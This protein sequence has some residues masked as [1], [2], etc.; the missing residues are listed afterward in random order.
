MYRIFRT[1]ICITILAGLA[2][3]FAEN[4][5]NSKGTVGKIDN[6]TYTYSE[7]NQILNNY[8][9]FWQSRDG[10][11]LTADRKKQLNDQCWEELIGRAIYDGEIKRR[12]I[13]ITDTEAYNS[14]LA[15]PP[16]QVKQ[17]ESL[18]TNGKFDPAKFKKALEV[19][20]K[21]KQQVMDLVKETMVYDRLFYVIKSQVKAKPDSIKQ[22]WL[23]DNNLAS[24][25]IIVFD[26]NKAKGITVADSEAFKYYNNNKETYK[27]DPARKYKFVKFTQDMYAEKSK[28]KAKAD[29]LYQVIKAG[30][31]FA[32]LATTFSDD[33]GSGK[34]GGELGWFTREKMVKPFADAA[35]ALDVNGISVPVKSQFG[36]HIIQTE[37]KRK[38]EQGQD[39]V[40]AR[41]LLV[42]SEPEEAIKQMVSA[43]AEKFLVAAKASGL[44]TAAAA[45]NYPVTETK[46]FYE[47]NKGIQEYSG[48][49]ELVTAAFSNPV[50]FIPP[51]FTGRNGEIYV[52]EISDSLG[53]HYLPFEPEKATIIKAVEKEK[54]IA[55]NKAY[56]REF[57]KKHNSLDY[58]AA[59]AA[60]SLKIVEAADVKEGS[61]IPEINTVKA[62]NDSLLATEEGKFTRLIET[63]TNVYLAQVTK[64][65]KPVMANWEKQKA[66][67]IAKANE[68]MK[69][70]QLNNWYYGQRQKM[71]LEDNRKD[72]YEL[73]KPQSN[74]QQI[75]LK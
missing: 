35:F 56:A 57:Y 42:K 36:W 72:F 20:A 49:P 4:P 19:D 30:G 43:D 8:F 29:S 26:Y 21:F 47:K 28:A 27:R 75:Q 65:V 32:T 63:D 6:K 1:A 66:K 5:P 48:G 52:S 14:I 7:Y 62:L 70:Q 12:K 15:T 60:D 25:K 46:E 59:A 17:I 68:D 53:I 45:M 73:N 40:R 71:K 38:N 33:P 10:K 54:K 31:D 24:A 41:H 74:T 55:A 64:R 61:S 13:V 39:E 16:A 58:L 67:L 11:K 50:G 34:N 2:V 51:N 69:T 23:K 9:N 44:T 18:K 22:V 3:L 37:E